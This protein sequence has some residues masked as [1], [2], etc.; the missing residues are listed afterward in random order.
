M[1]SFNGYYPIYGIQDGLGPE[2]HQILGKVHL[3]MELDDW[4]QSPQLLHVN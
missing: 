2:K 1:A 3:R 4:Y